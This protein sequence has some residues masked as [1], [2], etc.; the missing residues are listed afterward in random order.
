[1]VNGSLRG[2]FWPDRGSTIYLQNF[3]ACFFFS[4]RTICS[5]SL[6]RRLADEL[7]RTSARRACG[8]CV[9]PRAH[10]ATLLVDR[11]SYRIRTRKQ[12]PSG[13]WSMNFGASNL[14]YDYSISP[15][16][17]WAVADGGTRF[18]FAGGGRPEHSHIPG[19]ATHPR[20]PG[21]RRAGESA[22]TDVMI[23]SSRLTG[24]CLAATKYQGAF[25]LATA[26]LPG[27]PA[28]ERPDS[29]QRCPLRAT[30]QVFR[31]AFRFLFGHPAAAGVLEEKS[32]KK[33][34]GPPDMRHRRASSFSAGEQI[35]ANEERE[36]LDQGQ[37][38]HNHGDLIRFRRR[39]MKPAWPKPVQKPY[40]PIISARP[41]LGARAGR[42]SVPLFMR[43]GGYRTAG[44]GGSRR[45][46]A[47]AFR[48]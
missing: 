24:G 16:G 20:G 39:W 5:L 47:R 48:P 36:R 42:D 10:P 15:A 9:F 7:V 8:N 32:L 44:R 21:G 3:R 22:T 23:L 37:P 14:L 38:E 45:Y 31:A 13:G 2:L 29:A 1:M 27:D 19:P 12:P 35:K 11:W 41:F 46:L 43:T 33:P 6:A 4:R 18:D 30:N 28:R 40:Q 25:S 26:I 34:Q 17:I